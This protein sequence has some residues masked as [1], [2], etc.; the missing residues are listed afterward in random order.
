MRTNLAVRRERGCGE[1]SRLQ[2]LLKS[3]G[4]ENMLL[5]AVNVLV[6]NVSSSVFKAPFGVFKTVLVTL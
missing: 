4:T 6:V 5:F 3:A 2:L 1:R